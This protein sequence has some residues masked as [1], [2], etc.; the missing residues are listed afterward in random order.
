[1]AS[2]G[3]KTETWT[4]DKEF[5]FS[6]GHRVWNQKLDP[7]YC[8]GGDASCKCRHLHGH[9]GVVRV[10]M[11]GTKLDGGMIVDFNHLGWFSD[12]INKHL[13]HKFIL[14]LN[15]PWFPQ[16]LNAKPVYEGSALMKLSATQ[17]LNTKDGREI[18][19]RGIHVDTPKFSHL[20]GYELHV[21]D[22]SG[23]EKEFY[24]GFFL[25]NFLPTSENIAKWIFD[26]VSLK[27]SSINVEVT[28]VE[29][30]ESP[31]SRAVYEQV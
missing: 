17:P 11:S 14:D 2:I 5:D 18:L 13:D 9:R 4:I 30:S 7:E 24:Q 25:V 20:T 8:T 10:Y 12:F 6:Y 1:M 22:M 27:M 3:S 29:F 23:P 21:D 16:I 28:R 19:V 15:D 31:R 26:C